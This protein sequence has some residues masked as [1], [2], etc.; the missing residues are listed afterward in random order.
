[1]VIDRWTGEISNTEPQK[2]DDLAW[3]PLDHL[4][5]NTI[6]YVRYAIEKYQIGVYYSE[7]GWS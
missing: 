6:P 7:F 1:M 5:D 4:P 2:C 3:F